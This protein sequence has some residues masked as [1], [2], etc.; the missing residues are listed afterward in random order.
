MLFMQIVFEVQF[1][2]QCFNCNFYYFE[3][4]YLRNRFR[5]IVMDFRKKTK[6]TVAHG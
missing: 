6:K 1:K 2:S 4:L 5:K 3:N